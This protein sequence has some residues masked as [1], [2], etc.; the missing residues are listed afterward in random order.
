MAAGFLRPLGN[1]SETH[2][3]GIGIEY[4]PGTR[5]FRLPYTPG[6]PRLSFIYNGGLAYY[7][8][9]KETV[10]NYPYKYPGYLLVYALGGI[11]IDPFRNFDLLLTAGPGL[12][13]HNGSTR[14]AITS[15]LDANYFISQRLILGPSLIMMKE[16]KSDPLWSGSLRIGYVF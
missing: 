8:G 1:F 16:M 10:S 11:V 12:G 2:W 3:G 14:F 9:K 7:F 4:T 5:I 13:F 6:K 15:K